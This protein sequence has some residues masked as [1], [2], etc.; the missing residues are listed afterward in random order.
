MQL[1]ITCDTQLEFPLYISLGANSCAGK[2]VR[3]VI[4]FLFWCL[5]IVVAALTFFLGKDEENKEKD[6]SDSD[7]EVMVLSP[8]TL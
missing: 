1:W 3:F 5:Q 8:L 6:D 2:L 4:Y 7:Q